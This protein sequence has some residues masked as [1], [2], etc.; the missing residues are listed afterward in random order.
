MVTNSLSF[1]NVSSS[2]ADFEP[3]CYFQGGQMSLEVTFQTWIIRGDD[4]PPKY[5]DCF[6]RRGT[7]FRKSACR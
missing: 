6:D 4:Q 1:Q 2:S 5:R 7:N 3:Y